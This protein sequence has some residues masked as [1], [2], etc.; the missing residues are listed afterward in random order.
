MSRMFWTDAERA[1]QDR[2]LL[3]SR[4][5][6]LEEW[7]KRE[8]AEIERLREESARLSASARYWSGLAQKYQRLYDEQ[9]AK[10]NT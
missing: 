7:I 3:Y 9:R 5:K 1:E 6:E 10:P 8:T 2:A 4:I